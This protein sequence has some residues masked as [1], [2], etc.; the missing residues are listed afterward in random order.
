MRI[1]IPQRILSLQRREWHIFRILRAESREDRGKDEY[2]MFTY[3]AYSRGRLT[4][5]DSR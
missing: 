4:T 5:S 3:I 2:Q 1:G